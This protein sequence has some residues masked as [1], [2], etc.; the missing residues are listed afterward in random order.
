[1]GEINRT[2]TQENW[3]DRRG[4]LPCDDDL[5]E[6]LPHPS[7]WE[8]PEGRCCVSPIRLGDPE[9]REP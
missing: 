5:K 7:D 2:M 8:L 9:G 6:S 1:M 4:S 3:E